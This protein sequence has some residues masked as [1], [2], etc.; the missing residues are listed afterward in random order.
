VIKVFDENGDEF[1]KRLDELSHQHEWTQNMHS[2]FIPEEA[3]GDDTMA[4]NFDKNVMMINSSI[5]IL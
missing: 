2:I 1:S 5:G 4:E 3:E